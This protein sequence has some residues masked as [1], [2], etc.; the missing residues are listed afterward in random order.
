MSEEGE[1]MSKILIK[2]QSIKNSFET[3]EKINQIKQTSLCKNQKV[4]IA[5]FFH[6]LYAG[7]MKDFRA[8]VN[9]E[10]SDLKLDYIKINP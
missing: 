4:M 3:V 2:F 1:M 6:F 8:F 7:K 9:G 10:T 5:F